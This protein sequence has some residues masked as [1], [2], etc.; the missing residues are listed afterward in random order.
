MK[1]ARRFDDLG[2]RAGIWREFA[3]EF[4]EIL[5]EADRRIAADPNATR[6]LRDARE[7]CFRNAGGFLRSYRD[8]RTMRPVQEWGLLASAI[9]WVEEL[10]A[11]LSR[12]AVRTLRVGERPGR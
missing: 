3:V 11:Q 6:A 10:E 4:E 12:D 8:G 5:A 9:Q 2:D 1:V 7:R